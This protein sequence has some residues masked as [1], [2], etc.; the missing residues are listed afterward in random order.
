[1]REYFFCCTFFVVRAIAI[2]K[3]LHVFGEFNVIHFS[4]CKSWYYKLKI[5]LR[6][7]KMAT[8]WAFYYNN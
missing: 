8:S 7:Q 3:I 4:E 6:F 5:L 2:I 1:V